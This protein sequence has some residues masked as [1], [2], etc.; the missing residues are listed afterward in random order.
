MN[1]GVIGVFDSGVGGLKILWELRRVLPNERYVYVFDRSGAPYGNK[2][3][4][5]IIKR[6]EKASK[7]LIALGAKLIVVGCNTATGVAI[8]EL[9]KRFS[10]P[11]IGTE[12]PLRLAARETT[13]KILLLCT[14][15]TAASDNVKR[16]ITD[17]GT[18]RVIVAP[19]KTLASDIE[20]EF[21]ELSVLRGTLKHALAPYSD[22]GIGAVALGCT[23]YYYLK[24][25]IEEY[26][27]KTVKAFDAAGGVAA[28][29]ARV[30]D[31][32]NLAGGDVG[33]VR[34]VYM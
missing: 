11:F 6:A 10:V 20:R 25:M 19:Q 3:A 32:F 12:P 34:Y 5:Q 26:F 15:R 9:R 17:V 2:S 1:N 27:G 33:R 30:I 14:P 23:H 21:G 4:R 24:G 16:M 22:A 31:K 8:G 7:T 18:E 29:T 13:E 28:E